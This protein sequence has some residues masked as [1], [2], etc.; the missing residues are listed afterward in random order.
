MVTIT[1][2]CIFEWKLDILSKKSIAQSL[3]ASIIKGHKLH[4]SNEIVGEKNVI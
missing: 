2:N 3:S 1:I 4:M